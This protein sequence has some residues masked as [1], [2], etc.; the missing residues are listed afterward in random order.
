VLALPFH[1]AQGKFSQGIVYS[2]V[3]AQDL[4]MDHH[5]AQ[6]WGT[7]WTEIDAGESKARYLM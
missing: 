3:V 6:N 4:S 5:K 7:L 1:T 2:K